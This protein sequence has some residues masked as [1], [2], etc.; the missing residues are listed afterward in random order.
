M[1]PR[2]ATTGL[3][4]A[5]GAQAEIERLAADRR[6]AGGVEPQHD[7]LDGIVVPEIGN[8][9][10]AGGVVLD[11][12]GH[13]EPGHALAALKSKWGGRHQRKG[14]KC[15]DGEGAPDGDAPL[16]AAAVEQPVGIQA[17]HLLPD[18]GLDAERH[19]RSARCPP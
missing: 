12:P 13:P 11:Q 14:D 8:E 1:V 3:A 16:E 7:R 19:A 10:V 9:A 5:K 15:C 2:T 4:S 18:R 17:R 6:A